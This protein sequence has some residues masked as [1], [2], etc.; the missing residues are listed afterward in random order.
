VIVR[1]WR[2]GRVALL[3]LS[4]LVS[5]GWAAA[6]IP[7]FLEELLGEFQ[8]AYVS[9]RESDF[10]ALCASYD[11]D[12][13]DSG[14]LD[15]Y[16]R[17]SFL[18]DLLTTEGVSDCQRGGF[19]RI[20]YFWHWVDPN[21]RHRIIALPDSVL[22]ASLQAPPPFERYATFADI[23]R[24]PSLYL[25][26]LVSEMPRYWHPECGVFYSFGW[27]SEREMSYTALV[28]A[29]GY[30]A[31]IMQSGIHTQSRVWCEFARSDGGSRIIEAVI[32]NTFDLLSWEI[33]E[34]ASLDTWLQD[35][36]EGNQIAWYNRRA[37]SLEETR[38]L[39]DV[40]VGERARV[41]IRD[42]V[43]AGLSKRASRPPR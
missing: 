3:V 27:C 10:A 26:D 11:L 1:G 23:D 25:G 36:G 34:S 42:L 38:A 29:W 40:T 5:P 30:A 12:A 13:L 35:V 24:V 43:R 17:I 18:H 15:T 4:L 6:S 41:R 22:L 33:P 16:T 37:R 20:P 39:G 31:K 21:P 9:Y 7:A 32:D 19:L 2:L 28:T 8:G 14:N